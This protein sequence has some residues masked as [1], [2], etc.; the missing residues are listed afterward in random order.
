MVRTA[1]SNA[2]K[3]ADSAQAIWN[4]LNDETAAPASVAES[5]LLRYLFLEAIPENQRNNP[6]LNIDVNESPAFGRIRD[7]LSQI[8][9]YDRDPIVKPAPGLIP[10]PLSSNDVVVYCDFSRFNTN[11]NCNGNV[12]PG[13]ACDTDIQEEMF[14]GKFGEYLA[15]QN[16][17]VL[18]GPLV[19]L[20]TAT[21]IFNRKDL[22]NRRRGRRITKVRI[23]IT[24][25]YLRFRYARR[26]WTGITPHEC[27]AG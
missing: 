20:F 5:D 22:T 24:I 15:C 21:P 19:R 13:W 8:L 12:R 2:F 26:H 11:R 3:L 7:T 14:M 1:M 10:F 23:E 17:P 27:R 18:A 9:I 25:K 6:N 4:H 16:S